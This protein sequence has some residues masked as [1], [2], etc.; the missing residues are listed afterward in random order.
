MEVKDKTRIALSI[1]LVMSYL[2]SLLTRYNIGIAE[3]YAYILGD[4]FKGM[5]VVLAILIYNNDNNKD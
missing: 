1:L 4:F 3:D 2:L 5:C